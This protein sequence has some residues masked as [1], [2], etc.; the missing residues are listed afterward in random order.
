MCAGLL[1]I[2][3]GIKDGVEMSFKESTGHE[4]KQTS[5]VSCFMC[6]MK[7]KSVKTFTFPDGDYWSQKQ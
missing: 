1:E 5:S 7:K 3:K 2:L 6:Q 4:A